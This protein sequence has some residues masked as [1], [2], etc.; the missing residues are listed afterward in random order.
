MVFH[1]LTEIATWLADTCAYQGDRPTDVIRQQNEAAWDSF[2][3]GIS[4][5][6]VSGQRLWIQPISMGS[7]LN[8]IET[9]I[10]A[11]YSVTNGEG[12]DIVS[13]LSLAPGALDMGLQWTL[14]QKASEIA[15]HLR[16]FGL[17][18][19]LMPGEDGSQGLLVSNPP[20][21]SAV[22]VCLGFNSSADAL[23]SDFEVHS[24]AHANGFL[25]AFID[26]LALPPQSLLK[27]LHHFQ[28]TLSY[29]VDSLYYVTNQQPPDMVMELSV[30]N[31]AM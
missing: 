10:R 9:V 31:E 24:E 30:L 3:C 14:P 23:A 13:Y 20:E 21:G 19:S 8:S 5:R 22:E 16:H 27:D 29:L 15:A 6:M 12:C 7:L 1:N 4:Q 26:K 17:D 18:A 28:V 2:Q 11:T 25:F